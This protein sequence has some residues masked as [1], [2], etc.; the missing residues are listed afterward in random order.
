MESEIEWPMSS[1]LPTYTQE[2]KQQVVEEVLLTGKPKTKTAKKYG[3]SV[4]SVKNWVKK[5]LETHE[6]RRTYQ[7][8]EPVD[9]TPD[10]SESRDGLLDK[11]V[12]EQELEREV[13]HLKDELSFIRRV[14]AYV[15]QGSQ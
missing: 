3:V 8:D 1:N 11:S 10:P 14:A 7:P 13:Q 6:P 2:L 12:R 9:K 5:Y 15:A 4:G